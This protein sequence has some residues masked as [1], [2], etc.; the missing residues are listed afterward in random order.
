RAKAQW[1]GRCRLLSHIVARGPGKSLRT[2]I[3]QARRMEICGSLLVGP[4]IIS[5]L[6]TCVSVEQS[7]RTELNITY[8]VQH[9]GG[10]LFQTKID[11]WR[12]SIHTVDSASPAM[13]RVCLIFLLA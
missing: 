2:L 6:L 10:N 12:D 11:W 7:G 3:V 8:I 1:I 5:A 9:G 4:L 13:N